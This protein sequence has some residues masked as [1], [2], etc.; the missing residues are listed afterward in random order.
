LPRRHCAENLTRKL[1][2]ASLIVRPGALFDV[3]D[4]E[5]ERIIKGSRDVE[6]SA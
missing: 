1:L 5:S 4:E 6:L 2:P 3:V